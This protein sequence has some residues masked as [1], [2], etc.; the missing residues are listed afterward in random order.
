VDGSV[1]NLSIHL[2]PKS[3]FF[4]GQLKKKITL[5]QWANLENGFQNILP[6]FSNS[7]VSTP[8]ENLE[9]IRNKVIIEAKKIMPKRNDGDNPDE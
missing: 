6:F 1:D 2:I 4:K 9:S 5:T 7:T 3:E 8:I